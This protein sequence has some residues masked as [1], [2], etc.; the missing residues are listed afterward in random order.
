LYQLYT[1]AIVYERQ[2]EL[3]SEIF[4]REYKSYGLAG[5]STEYVLRPMTFPPIALSNATYDSSWDIMAIYSFKNDRARDLLLEIACHSNEKYDSLA[6]WAAYYLTLFPNS[7]ELLLKLRTLLKE[8][9]AD[10]RENYPD[11]ANLLLNENGELT[12]PFRQYPSPSSTSIHPKVNGVNWSQWITLANE[13]PRLFRLVRLVRALEFNE[14]IPVDE[15]ERFGTFRRELAIS[16]SMSNKRILSKMSVALPQ[17]SATLPKGYEHF[18]IY[19]QEYVPPYTKKPNFR[20]ENYHD[21]YPYTLEN[22]YHQE[23]KA[24]YEREPAHPRPIYTENQIEYIKAT[25]ERTLSWLRSKTSVG[26][27]VLR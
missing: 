17:M 22:P 9:I 16:W 3:L 24:F 7:G 15:R 14:K 11:R 26:L 10:G 18:E 19:F 23:R 21:P 27:D 20:W 1:L 5:Y 12:N 6:E 4:C 25:L 8:A 13:V 2:T